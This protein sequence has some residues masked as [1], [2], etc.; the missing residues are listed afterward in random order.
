V[1][2]VISP[3][4]GNI[5]EGASSSTIMSL[6]DLSLASTTHTHSS[7]PRFTRTDGP[8]YRAARYVRYKSHLTK[9]LGR[10][11][12]RSLPWPRVFDR[13]LCYQRATS[14]HRNIATFYINHWHQ[15]ITLKS[16]DTS[17]ILDIISPSGF[18]SYCDYLQSD[19]SHIHT[20]LRT[21]R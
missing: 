12:R 8:P 20:N 16:A 4:R 6:P 15:H 5:W 11:A 3:E 9:R 7:S 18:A 19:N 21:P 13:K 10:F 14:Q 1:A 17:S 2:D